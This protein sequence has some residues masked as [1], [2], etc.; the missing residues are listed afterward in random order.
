[1]GGTKVWLVQLS[2]CSLTFALLC[3]AP[4]PASPVAPTGCGIGYGASN[5]RLRTGDMCGDFCRNF[6]EIP[7]LPE[8]TAA[9]RHKQLIRRIDVQ[10]RTKEGIEFGEQIKEPSL[11]RV[12]SLI[13]FCLMHSPCKVK[14][15]ASRFRSGVQWFSTRALTMSRES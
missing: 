12:R 9:Q 8:Q 2:H 6:E 15:S 5:E 14:T 7:A 4:Y 10:S 11:Q 3:F 13:R 1:M